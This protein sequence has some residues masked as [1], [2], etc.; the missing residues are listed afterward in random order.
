MTIETC[1]SDIH[2]LDYR[3]YII[4]LIEPKD[5]KPDEGDHK[6]ITEVI[7]KEHPKDY[8]ETPKGR[9]DKPARSTDSV[10]TVTC[11]SKKEGKSVD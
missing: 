11:C 3:C 10:S 5:A 8:S 4:P 1:A 7:H 2:R 6:E 9:E